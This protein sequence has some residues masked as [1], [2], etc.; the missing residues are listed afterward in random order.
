VDLV[1]KKKFLKKLRIEGVQRKKS[2]FDK[3][4]DDPIEEVM[5]ASRR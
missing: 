3:Y 5:R 2:D 4:L 1:K